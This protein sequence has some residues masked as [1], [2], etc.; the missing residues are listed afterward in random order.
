[1]GQL[2]NLAGAKLD[3][4]AA[5]Y[6]EDLQMGA[7][8]FDTTIEFA[9]WDQIVKLAR[10]FMR[11]QGNVDIR[12]N[13]RVTRGDILDSFPSSGAT[14]ALAPLMSNSMCGLS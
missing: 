10:I 6:A 4:P 3:G 1:M 9:N 14:K 7:D 12:Y 2:D 8:G 13:S 11:A 5:L